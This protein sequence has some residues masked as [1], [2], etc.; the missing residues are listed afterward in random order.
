MY[1]AQLALATL[2]KTDHDVTGWRRHCI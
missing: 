2:K 1:G